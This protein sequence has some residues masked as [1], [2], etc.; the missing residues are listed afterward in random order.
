MS[1]KLFDE[2][3][4]VQM[5]RHVAIVM[6]G[7]GRWA[8]KRGLLRHVGHEQG[9]KTIQ[10]I[11][12]YAQ[13]LEIPY[14]TLYAFSHENWQR[15]Q[16]EVDAIMSILDNYLKNDVEEL[17]KQNVQIN[18]IGH[19]NRLPKAVRTSLNKVIEKT[20]HCKK[21]TITLAL[22]YS[23]WQEIVDACRQIV[24]EYVSQP[25]AIDSINEEMLK[26]ALYT[27]NLPF[28]DLFIRTGGE[29]RLSNFLLLQ[30]SYSEL[31]FCQELWPDFK[32]SDF[33]EA[34]L[35]FSRR[36]RRFGNVSS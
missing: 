27:K 30:I 8:E 12:R 3:S 24:K 9:A 16:D 18:A 10:D 7:N 22:S 23:S 17:V 28:P 11:I 21:M 19:I 14:I 36:K 34:I 35:S 2:T 4:S 29:V 31:Y 5:P 25:F 33:K 13:E 1:I 20:S 26:N 6:D 15:P 32:R